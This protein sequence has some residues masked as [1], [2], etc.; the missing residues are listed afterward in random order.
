MDERP[1][2]VWNEVRVSPDGISISLISE[3]AEGDGPVVEAEEMFAFEELEEMAPTGPMTMRLS[4]KTRDALR[5]RSRNSAESDSRNSAK[6]RTIMGDT[7][8]LP[9]EGEVVRDTEAPDWSDT[10][11]VIVQNVTNSVASDY[12]IE[13]KSGVRRVETV[14]T[15]NLNHPP[16]A[17]VVEAAYLSVDG[18]QSDTYAFPVTRLDF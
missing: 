13:E 6:T 7:F 8:T 15:L 9:E 10:G 18:G 11:Q 17:P 1:I 3:S 4:D 2:D 14:N 16:N 12:V 5:E